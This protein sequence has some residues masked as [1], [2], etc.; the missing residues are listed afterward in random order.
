P[1][2]PGD[3]LDPRRDL[4]I[5]IALGAED[6]DQ[7]SSVLARAQVDLGGV[8]LVVAALE[9]GRDAVESFAHLIL[10]DLLEAVQDDVIA[11]LAALG[12]GLLAV[13][14]GGGGQL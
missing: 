2:G 10:I 12:G 11:L 5:V 8:G 13:G 1:V 9:Q 3:A 6:L 14:F 7:G 4:G